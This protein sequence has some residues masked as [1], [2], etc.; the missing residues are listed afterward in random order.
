MIKSLLHTVCH[1]G[2]VLT[3]LKRNREVR[4]SNPDRNTGC[5]DRESTQLLILSRQCR[6]NN[7]IMSRPLHFK[8]N[9]ALCRTV[10]LVTV[11]EHFI[12][13]CRCREAVK[14]FWFLLSLYSLSGTCSNIHFSLTATDGGGGGGAPHFYVLF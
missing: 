10:L 7:S 8:S 3:L 9:A 14:L 6:Y 5:S 11:Q 4:G 1:V 12:A 2:V 13:Y